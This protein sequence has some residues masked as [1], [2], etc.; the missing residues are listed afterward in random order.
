M[1]DLSPPSPQSDS[2]DPAL[3]PSDPTAERPTRQAILRGFRRR[4]PCC[5][6]G[7][8]M[9]GYLKV[10]DNCPVCG[11]ALYH[12]RADDGPPYLTLLIVGHII[13][14]A[15]L[16]FYVRFEPDPYTFMAIFMVSAT[17]LS[18]WFLPRLKGLIVSV[19]WANRMHGFGHP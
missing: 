2:V 16:W 18:L 4:C 10:R 3:C 12:H 5:G 11:E 1:R 7:P 17:A 8:M 15:M 14:P 19:Q 9:Q 13:G 6:S